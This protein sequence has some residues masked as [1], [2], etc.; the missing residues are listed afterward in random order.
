MEITAALGADLSLLTSTLFDFAA[1]P[2][3]DVAASILELATTTRLA[4][5]SFR[6]LSITITRRTRALADQVVLRLTLL[7]DPADPGDIKT[8]LLLPAPTHTTQDLPDIQVV[9]YA[10]SLG[11]FV[12][13]AA[14]LAFLTGSAF[15]PAD[16]DR[17]QSLAHEPDITG[18]VQHEGVINQAIGALIGRGSTR[19]QAHTELDTLVEQATTDR[20]TEASRILTALTSGG[21]G[22]SRM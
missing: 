20:A 1:D 14:D 15:N 18:V 2:G 8:S 12:D 3:T 11:A 13:L 7:D 21:T 10:A 17:H 9:L 22:L 5:D 16:L 4:V 6:G 19:E